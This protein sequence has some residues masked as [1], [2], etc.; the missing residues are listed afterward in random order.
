MS[1]G[2]AFFVSKA[3][4]RVFDRLSHICPQIENDVKKLAKIIKLK[5]GTNDSIYPSQ[6]PLK[7]KWFATYQP[8]SIVPNNF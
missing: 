3:G 2:I 6:I 5:V 7:V 8:H 4:Q 1:H